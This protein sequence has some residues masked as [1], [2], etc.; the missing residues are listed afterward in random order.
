VHVYL[1]IR[2]SQWV[3]RALTC[4]AEVVGVRLDPT[5]R[6]LSALLDDLHDRHGEFSRLFGGEG[7]VRGRTHITK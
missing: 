6:E 4:N 1:G 7:R 2:Y 3:L 5:E